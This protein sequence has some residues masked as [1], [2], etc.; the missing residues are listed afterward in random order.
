MR[1]VVERMHMPEITI[2][3]GQTEIVAWN[4]HVAGG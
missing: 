4:H 2:V 3:Y 1:H